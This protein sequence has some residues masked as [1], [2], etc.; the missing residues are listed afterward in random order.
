MFETMTKIMFAAKFTVVVKLTEWK[1]D[2]TTNTL[3]EQPVVQ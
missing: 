3:I 2:Q 1:I